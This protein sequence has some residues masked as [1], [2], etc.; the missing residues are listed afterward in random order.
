MAQTRHLALASEPGIWQVTILDGSVLTVTAHGYSEEE[1][2][3]VFSL[4]MEGQ[5]C[6]EIDILR[7]PSNLVSKIRGG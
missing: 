3:Y 1:A 4:L 2:T 6:F 5:P 7:I